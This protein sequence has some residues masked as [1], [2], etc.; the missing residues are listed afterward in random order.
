MLG[1]ALIDG[2]EYLLVFLF[3]IGDIVVKHTLQFFHSRLVVT[4]GAS[5]SEDAVLSS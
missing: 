3:H 1:I 2:F 5:I 4:L